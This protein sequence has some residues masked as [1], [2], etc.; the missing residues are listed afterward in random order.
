MDRKWGETLTWGLLT[1]WDTEQCKLEHISDEQRSV[2]HLLFVACFSVPS[3]EFQRTIRH[4]IL[5]EIILQIWNGSDLIEFG[6]H[7][8]AGQDNYH[9]YY[10]SR[11]CSGLGTRLSQRHLTSVCSYLSGT[12]CACSEPG[13]A[14]HALQGRLQTLQNWAAV[15]HSVT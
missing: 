10:Y 4:Y 3:V 6:Y 15:K 9:S 8:V 13:L 14:G 12:Q 1:A 2:C 11:R 5:E 7:K